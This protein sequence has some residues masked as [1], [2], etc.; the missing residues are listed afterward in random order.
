MKFVTSLFCI[1]LLAGCAGTHPKGTAGYD[2]YDAVKVEQMVGNNVSQAVFAKTIVCLNARR[3]TRRLTALTNTLVTSATNQTVTA[4]TNLTISFATNLLSSSMTNLSPALPPPTIAAGDAGTGTTE[5]N[6]AMVVSNSA[7]SV[8]TNVT[9]SFASN[10]SGTRAPNQM[11]ANTQTIRTFNNQVTTTSNNLSV[12]VMTNLVLTGETNLVVFYVT[13]TSVV[14]VTNTIVTP[15]TGAAYDYFLCT[16]LIPP[17]DFTP[18]PQGEALVLLV[19]G[20]RH[21]FSQSQSSTSFIARKGYTSALYRVSPEALVA[22]ANAKEVRLR[23]KG[24]NSVVER[25][26]SA[27]SRQNFRVFLERYFVPGTDPASPEKSAAAIEE[28]TH[29]ANR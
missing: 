19:D 11:T 16:E 23:L 6:L 8:T 29:V 26:M 25:R 27:G 9:V 15:T 3:E 12:A 7:P 14:S 1:G 5:T 21:G 28:A 13:N 22:I 4:I 10:S 2:D 24:V 20:V 17:A 18:L